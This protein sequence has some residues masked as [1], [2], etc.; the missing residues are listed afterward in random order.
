M[1]ELPQHRSTLYEALAG[2][3][4]FPP[5]GERFPQLRHTPAPLGK[6]VPRPLTELVGGCLSPDPAARPT[7][8]AVEAALEEQVAALPAPRIRRRR[9]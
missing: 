8:A 6:R 1:P 4:P 3:P 5:D 9:A 7:A 2:V